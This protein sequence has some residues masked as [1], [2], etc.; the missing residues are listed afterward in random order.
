MMRGLGALLLLIAATT[1]SAEVRTDVHVVV[2]DAPV[3]FSRAQ[4]RIIYLNKNG[5]TLTPGTTDSRID[6]S[7]MASTQ[8]AIPPWRASATLWADTVACVREAF[9]PFDVEITETDPGNVPHLEAVFGGVPALLGM[10]ARTA[11]VS[12]FSTSCKVIENSMVFTFA[13]SIP[14]DAKIAC[15]VMAQEIAHSYGL[16]HQLLAPDPMSYLPYA[17]KRA[18]QDMLAECG[19]ATARPCGVQGYASCRDGQN[20][21]ALL[22]ERLGPAGTGEP[23]PAPVDSP[24]EDD[25]TPGDD[26]TAAGCSAANGAGVLT[27]LLVL[28]LL[29]LSSRRA[30]RSLVRVRPRRRVR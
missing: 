27:C 28:V 9:A 26:A 2:D 20:S 25:A 16:D 10:S 22:L 5:V 23:G 30:E 15:E 29:A 19:E 6:R 7:A 12:P 4:S 13:D 18:F 21:Y 8:V 17:G 11:G 14:Q 24:G 3:A 1:A